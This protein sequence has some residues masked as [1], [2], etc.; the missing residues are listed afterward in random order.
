MKQPKRVKLIVQSPADRNE[1][2]ML[3]YA[4]AWAAARGIARDTHHVALLVGEFG[5]ARFNTDGSGT[6]EWNDKSTKPG[7]TTKFGE[8]TTVAI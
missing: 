5:T 1:S 2:T 8:R 7:E 6:V 3:P 4:V